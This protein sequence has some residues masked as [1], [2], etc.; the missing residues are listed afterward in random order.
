MGPS[1]AY[2]RARLW[3]HRTLLPAAAYL[4]RRGNLIDQ[5]VGRADL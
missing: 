1:G 5:R 3:E 2:A 4:R